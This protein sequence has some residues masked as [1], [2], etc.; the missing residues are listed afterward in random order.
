MIDRR[1]FLQTTVAGAAGLVLTGPAAAAQ[2]AASGAER[3]AVVHVIEHVL[4]LGLDRTRRS[5]LR[6]HQRGRRALARKEHEQR[7][8]LQRRHTSE[9][10]AAVVGPL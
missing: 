3:D 4:H 1:E 9:L 6:L 5:L 10:R 8:K 7:R 2:R